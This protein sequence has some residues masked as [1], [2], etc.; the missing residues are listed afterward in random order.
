MAAKPNV[1]MIEEEKEA[2]DT[3]LNAR[4]HGA[5]LPPEGIEECI[6]EA[7]A[8]YDRNRNIFKSFEEAEYFFMLP[9]SERQRVRVLR[10][11][12]S[13]ALLARCSTQFEEKKDDDDD[14][15]SAG[16]V[17]VSDVTDDEEKY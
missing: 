7:R 14:R 6:R 13:R 3:N 2:Y 8:Y 12:C 4:I 16:C 9:L 10:Q 1:D 11:M 17:L 15:A 5:D